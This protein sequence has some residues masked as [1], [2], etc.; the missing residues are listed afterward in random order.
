[1]EEGQ[2]EANRQTDQTTPARLTLS[3]KGA[4]T[5]GRGRLEKPPGAD[6]EL[7]E[8]CEL[9]LLYT[10]DAADDSIRV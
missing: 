6:E 7:T 9:C 2:T 10:S 8:W 1:M 5:Q 4:P 3:D